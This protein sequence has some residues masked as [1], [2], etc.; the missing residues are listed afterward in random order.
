MRIKLYGPARSEVFEFYVPVPGFRADYHEVD[1]DALAA[2]DFEEFGR[3]R[4]GEPQ[5]A[6]AGD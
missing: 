5:G 6:E 1:W 2:Q 4:A 3:E